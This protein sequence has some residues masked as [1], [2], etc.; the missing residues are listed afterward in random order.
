MS[1]LSPEEVSILLKTSVD[2]SGVDLAQISAQ[3]KLSPAER[4]DWLVAALKGLESFRGR[5]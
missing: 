4:V 5:L 3:L 1:T 2:E